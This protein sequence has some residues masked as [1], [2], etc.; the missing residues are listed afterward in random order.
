MSKNPPPYSEVH[1]PQPGFT[2]P[3]HPNQSG[4]RE[5]ELFLIIHYNLLISKFALL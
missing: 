2:V 5:E 3:P 4:K 1:P